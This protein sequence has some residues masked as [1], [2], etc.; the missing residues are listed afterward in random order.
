M[1]LA[2]DPQAPPFFSHHFTRT[3]GLDPATSATL[4]RST[5]ATPL[6]HLPHALPPPLWPTFSTAYSDRVAT[7]PMIYAILFP[8]TPLALRTFPAISASFSSCVIPTCICFYAPPLRKCLP[9]ALYAPASKAFPRHKS[10][11]LVILAAMFGPRVLPLPS[12]E[13]EQ[14][15]D[16]NAESTRPAIRWVL[17]LPLPGQEP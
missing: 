1:A 17:L 15:D 10:L 7:W 14:L 8:R 9:G 5:P 11:I 2:L 12:K 16:E 3:A 6:P 4:L 13:K